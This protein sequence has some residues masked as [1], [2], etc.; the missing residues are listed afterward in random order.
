MRVLIIGGSG[1]IGLPVAQAFVRA[2]HIVYVV[3]RSAQ[4]AKL[5]A[6]EEIIPI[7]AETTEAS[8]WL[9]LVAI[10][11]AVVEIIGG[12]AE[13][14][15]L[16]RMLFNVT[17]EAAKQYRPPHAPKLTYICTTGIWV[18]GD[19]REDIVTDTTPLVNPISF[20]SW[21]PEHE[22]RVVHNAVVNGI[23]IRPALLYGRSGSILATMFKK[24]YEG[25]V[26]WYGTP[27]GRYSLIHCDDLADMYVLATEKAAVVG[28]T[29]FDAANDFTESV[30]DIL[31][32]LVQVSGAQ[33]PYQYI[34]PSNPFE[35]AITTTSLLRPYLAR[36]L[37]GWQPRK[38]GLVDHLEIYYNAWK[39]S[40]GL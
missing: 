28:G 36:S 4:K 9:P 29:I 11:D 22:Q 20:T 24:A 40:Q 15:V 23:V 12:V 3:T 8:T 19:N 2:G 1:F 32:K 18:H 13:L 30:D 35:T 37:L 5:L 16:S 39:A 38:A 26:E 17:V 34:A 33:G 7:V 27:G 31:H 21:R 14:K 25:R 6:A 10:L